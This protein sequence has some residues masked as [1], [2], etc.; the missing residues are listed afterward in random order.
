M[1]ILLFSR[2]PACPPGGEGLEV[3]PDVDG[4]I[5]SRDDD[6]PLTWQGDRRP[7]YDYLLIVFSGDDLV[8]LAK[9]E[10]MRE[11][12]YTKKLY[13]HK[14]STAFAHQHCESS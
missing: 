6:W 14:I 5:L 8:A 10:N 4:P 1:L 9:R 7:Y 13:T 11:V 3:V 2:A 12:G